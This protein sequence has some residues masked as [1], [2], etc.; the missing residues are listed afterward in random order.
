MS[1]L[2]K[3]MPK[4]VLI[5]LLKILE[6]FCATDF[7]KKQVFV[8]ILVFIFLKMSQML[9]SVVFWRDSESVTYAAV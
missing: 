6:N 3:L 4:F 7:A 5:V 8:E 9:F 1:S 2:Q